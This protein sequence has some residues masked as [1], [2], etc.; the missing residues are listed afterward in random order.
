MSQITG[1]LHNCRR[2]MYST[3]S[4]NLI[5]NKKKEQCAT[6]VATATVD[7]HL[8]C[9]VDAMIDSDAHVKQAGNVRHAQD[10]NADLHNSNI[11]DCRAGARLSPDRD[12]ARL[13]PP[14]AQQA[15]E[16][17]SWFCGTCQAPSHGLGPVKNN[18]L[19]ERPRTPCRCLQDQPNHCN[20]SKQKRTEKRE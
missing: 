3:P 14:R 17:R 4:H 18:G 5:S 8:Q 6:T 12:H 13:A 9:S 11:G 1:K 16:L 7:L 19:S 2:R 10:R 20:V 15:V